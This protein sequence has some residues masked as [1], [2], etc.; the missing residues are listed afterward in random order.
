MRR[1]SLVGL[2]LAPCLLFSA[3]GGGSGSSGPG[4]PS[5]PS[6]P[7]TPSS[8]APNPCD[9]V[10]SGT[11]A[12]AALAPGKGDGLGNDTRD[13]RD[14]IWRHR[15]AGAGRVE[16]ADVGALAAPDVGNIGVLQDDGSLIISPNPF[17]LRGI[18]LRFQQNMGGGYDVVRIDPAFRSTLGGRLTLGDDDTTRADVPFAFPFFGRSRTAAFVN[19][20][21]NVTFE[22]GDASSEDRSLGR[23]L[24]GSPRV[25]PFFADLDPSSGGGVFLNAAADAYTVTWCKVP[26]F[27]SSQRVTA[28][29]SL[30]PDGSVEMKLADSTTLTAAVVAL[31]PGGTDSF[32]PLDLS[33]PGPFAGGA[34]AL[35]ERFTSERDLDTVAA[36]RRF[37]ASHPDVFDQLVFWTDTRVV[38]TGTFA[39]ES[40]TANDIRGIGTGIFDSSSEFGSAG[41]LSSF[42]VLDN[43]AKYPDDPTARIPGL[44]EDTTLSIVCHETGHRWGATLSFRDAVGQS[45]DLLL[46]RQRAHWS[47][48]FDSDAS[49]LEGNDIEDRGGGSFQTVGAAQRY[50]PLDLYAMGLIEESEVPTV[51]FVANP[52]GTSLDREAS[53]QTGVSFTGTRRDV[54]IG[55]IVAAMGPR[56]PSAR[57]SPRLHRQAFV[58]VVGAGRTADPAAIAKLERIR[59]AW[60]PYFNAATGSRMSV[61]TSLP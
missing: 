54:T 38:E 55:D 11:A 49:V 33:G 50:G 23:V 1:A 15:V 17:D 41:R 34:S 35:G 10:V 7:T 46:G 52:T 56:Q 20:D 31:S 5:T 26:G 16:T 28:Q 21:G 58:Y 51:F 3:C 32:Q 2:V 57:Q 29:A 14:L 44:G 18:G 12:V 8:F 25:A 60:E 47:F 59:Q 6:P 40:T 43:L 27:A 4:T 61:D 24:T 13:P 45:S 39:F 37:L 19:S 53:P 9:A 22:N 30:L 48:F 36:S 42:L